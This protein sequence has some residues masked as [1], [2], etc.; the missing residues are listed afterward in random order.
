MDYRFGK[1]YKLCRKKLI[2]DI[3]ASGTSVKKFPFLMH[4][5]CVDE[6]LEK[7]FQIVISVPKRIF[8]SAVQRNRVKRVMK[9]IIRHEKQPLEDFLTQQ[10]KYLTIF[11]VYT[12]KE[13]LDQSILREKFKKVTQNLIEEIK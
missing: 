6:V 3:F 12:G 8:R 1:E 13:E 7:P 11:W 4:Y 2:D 9:E 5:R 10:G